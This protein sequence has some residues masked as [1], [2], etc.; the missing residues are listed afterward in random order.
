M[1]R[2]SLEWLE[3]RY[4]RRGDVKRPRGKALDEMAKVLGHNSGK[5]LNKALQPNRVNRRPDRKPHG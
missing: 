1:A 4:R 5:A 3:A 2:V